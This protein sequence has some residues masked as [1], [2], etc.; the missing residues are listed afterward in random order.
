MNLKKLWLLITISLTIIG[1]KDNLSSPDYSLINNP[2][3]RWQAYRLT[4]YTI[5]QQRQCFC[6]FR[7]NKVTLKISNDNVI[8]AKYTDDNNDVNEDEIKI[9]RTVNQLFDFIDT[10]KVNHV[11]SLYVEYDSTYGYPKRIFIDQIKYA[12]DDELTIITNNF[13]PGFLKEN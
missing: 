12:V 8:E 4:A 5:E 11:D 13:K 1:C 10:L 9:Y 6:P 7:G 2:R 3:E